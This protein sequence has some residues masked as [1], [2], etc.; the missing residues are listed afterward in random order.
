[1]L[2]CRSVLPKLIAGFLLLLIFCRITEVCSQPNQVKLI[3]HSSVN[4]ASLDKDQVRRIFTMYQTNWSD[5]QPIV[6]YVLASNN[7]THQFFSREILG[8]FP[9]QLDRIWN[10][11]IYSGL[12]EAPTKVYSEQEMLE[13]IE[14]QPGS[15]GY[16]MSVAVPDDVNIVQLTEE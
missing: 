8:L 3:T 16:V 12:G 2:N 5:S 13:K 10:K 7:T 9:Y 4:T 6:V 15:I 11:L 14:Q 1:M